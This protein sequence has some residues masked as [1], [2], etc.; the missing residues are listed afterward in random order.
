MLA[1]FPGRTLEAIYVRAR[2]LKLRRRTWKYKKYSNRL[3]NEVRDRCQALGYTMRDL[4]D[5]AG[6]G[7]YFESRAW[8]KSKQPNAKAIFQAIKALGGKVRVEWVD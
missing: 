4:D 3:I 8:A 1:L 7:R 6:T 5:V 2:K